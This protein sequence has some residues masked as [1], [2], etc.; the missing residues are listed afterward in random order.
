MVGE[1]KITENLKMNKTKD[2]RLLMEGFKKGLHGS[3]KK[4]RTKVLKE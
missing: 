2:M 3:S 1:E 4:R